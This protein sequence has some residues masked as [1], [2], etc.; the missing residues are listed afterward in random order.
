MDYRSGIT[1]G[2]EVAVEQRDVIDVDDLT[3][4]S[5]WACRAASRSA[6]LYESS[7]R[8][9]GMPTTLIF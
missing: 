9:P 8:L 5:S 2:L 7:G 3:S 6:R 1:P 4:T